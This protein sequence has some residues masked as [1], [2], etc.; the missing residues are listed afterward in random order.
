MTY[1]E[2]F[3]RSFKNK[4]GAGSMFYT[5]IFNY[6]RDNLICHDEY[7]EEIAFV[8]VSKQD[9]S[10]TKEVKIPFKEKKFLRQQLRKEK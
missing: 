3:K 5:N 9:G 6:D 8:L 1:T 4:E 10:I 7:N 2:N